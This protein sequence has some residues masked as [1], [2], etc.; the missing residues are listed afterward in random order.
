MGPIL[1]A[2]HANKRLWEMEGKQI[3]EG[4]IDKEARY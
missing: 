2:L 4:V 1:E 3:Q